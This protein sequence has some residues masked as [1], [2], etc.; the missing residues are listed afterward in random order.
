LLSGVL[1]FEKLPLAYML[2]FSLH[3]DSLP[4]IPELKGS[5]QVFARGTI[6]GLGPRARYEA[7]INAPRL[8]L[9]DN[10]LGSSEITLKSGDLNHIAFSCS[11]KNDPFFSASGMVVGLLG[12]G[13]AITATAT[14]GKNT[15]LSILGA[16]MPFLAGLLDSAWLNVSCAGNADAF[17]MR[18]GFGFSSSPVHGTLPFQIDKIKNSKALRWRVGPKDLYINDTLAYCMAAGTVDEKTLSIDT[19]HALGGV[20]G[21]GHVD[22][23]TLGGLEINLKYRDVSL[24]AMNTWLFK[25]GLPIKNGAMFGG[26]RISG[27]HGRIT[28]E[29]EFHARKCEVGYLS[30]METDVVCR[31][32]DTLFTI[33]PMTI[34]KDGAALVFLDTISNSRGI[35]LS[36]RFNNIELRSVL[37]G[38][39]PDEYLSGENEAKGALSGTFKSL[40]TGLAHFRAFIFS[41]SQDEQVARWIQFRQTLKLKKTGWSSGNVPLLTETG[42]IS[43]A[44]EAFRG[45]FS[46]TP[47]DRKRRPLASGHHEPDHFRSG[48]LLASFEKNA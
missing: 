5:G 23:G 18:G 11:Q 13:P 32:N 39:V 2:S 7:T 42:C 17:D 25:R 22:L 15:V 38:I 35:S 14:L 41:T 9:F 16:R 24:G 44:P 12:K 30:N 36:G 26:T 8:C 48:D 33:L 4:R 28:T 21:S 43:C 29:S 31:S 46:S 27:A 40:H 3:A 47:A 1:N 20:R 34:K 45:R 10:K 37:S 19:L 6:T